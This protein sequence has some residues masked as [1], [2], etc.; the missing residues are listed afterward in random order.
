[1]EEDLHND[2]VDTDLDSHMVDW[3][4]SVP[5]QGIKEIL[6]EWEEEF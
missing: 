1:V 5:G 3:L 6:R 4:G 2:L